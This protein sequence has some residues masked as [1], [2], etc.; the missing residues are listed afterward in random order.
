MKRRVA[1]KRGK[2]AQP[3]HKKRA[4]GDDAFDW[5]GSKGNGDSNDV[6]A[7]DSEASAQASEAE[8]DESDEE[9]K[10]T[11]QEKRLRLA[12]E[13]LGKISTQEAGDAE[14]SEDEDGVEARVGA[15]LQQDALEALGKLF[16]KVAADYAEFEF[17]ADSTKFLK[18]HRLPVTSLCLLEDGQTAFS[19]A[20][21]G[22]LLRWDLAQQKKT[23]LTLPKDDVAAE[24]AKTDKDRCV[25]ALAAS[26]DGKF[27]ASGGRDKLVRVWDVEKGQL[28]ESFAGHRD[29]VSA[30]AFRLRSHSLFS[31]S[32]DRSIKH[33]NL[34]E[35]GYVETLFGHQSEVNALD[36][37]YKERVVSCGRDRSVRVWKI[38]EETQ[39]VFY[40]N[41]GS[42]DCVKMVTDEYYV[43]GGDDGSLSLWF[44]GRKKPVCVIQNAHG[45]KWISSVAV[46]P[47]TDLIASGSSDGQIRLW[48]ADLQ[49]RTLTAVASIPLEGFV[50]ALCFDHK[51]RFLLAGVGQEHRLGRWEKLKVKNGIAIIAL[52]SIDAEQEEADD[53][54]EEEAESDDES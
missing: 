45:G 44:N 46:M 3:P 37:L 42:M 34:T 32:L 1:I 30:L 12:K 54:E 18:G 38:P 27:L 9:H 25:L 49:A 53:E 4:L 43:T 48:Q 16:K 19:A 13:Y 14:Q 29:A 11:A 31:G 8:S 47:R 41:S 50:N 21:D 26:S 17:D 15:K 7:S 5:S 39:L 51:A 33:W 20:K 36:S 40:G 28:Q 2:T 35:M 24:K 6:I 52:P 10:E 23:K 22:S